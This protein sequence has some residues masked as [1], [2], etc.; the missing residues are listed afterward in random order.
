VDTGDLAHHSYRFS[1][2]ESLVQLGEK[3]KYVPLSRQAFQ[4][5]MK[6]KKSSES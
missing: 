6:N 5:R 3:D 2:E 1:D 4:E